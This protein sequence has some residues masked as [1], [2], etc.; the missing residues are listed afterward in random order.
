MSSSGL[1]M[2]TGTLHS[3]Y[4]GVTCVIA[5]SYGLSGQFYFHA[6][7]SNDTTEQYSGKLVKADDNSEDLR[8]YGCTS[9]YA[10]FGY[11]RSSSGEYDLMMHKLSGY[12]LAAAK[13]ALLQSDSQSLECAIGSIGDEIQLDGTSFDSDKERVTQETRGQGGFVVSPAAHPRQFVDAPLCV[14]WNR[15]EGST[16][17]SDWIGI[18][19]SGTS[20]LVTDDSWFNAWDS[21]LEHGMVFWRSLVPRSPGLFDIV[22]FAN[23]EAVARHPVEFVSRETMGVL[24][25]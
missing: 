7:Y 8:C 23:S 20:T 9:G 3:N 12:E 19:H 4:E 6:K 2:N 1:A 5:G 14:V 11:G 13:E 17:S 25:Q 16:G 21:R 24:H 22:Y 10:W 15:P 18:C